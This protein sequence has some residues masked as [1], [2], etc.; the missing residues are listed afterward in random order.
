MTKYF[1]EKKYSQL[2]GCFVYV[3]YKMNLF[4]RSFRE[5]IC[6]SSTLENCETDLRIIIE[7]KKKKKE[8]SKYDGIV[9]VIKVK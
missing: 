5:D 6:W 7:H 8:L 9:K 4:R 2:N 3:A 1:I